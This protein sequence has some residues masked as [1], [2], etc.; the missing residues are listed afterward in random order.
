MNRRVRLTVRL[1]AMLVTM[2]DQGAMRSLYPIALP[3]IDPP[4]PVHK[5]V[6]AILSKQQNRAYREGGL[7]RRYLCGMN[8]LP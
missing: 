3:V 2:K 5:I 8:Q 6:G 4:A 1:G 7:E